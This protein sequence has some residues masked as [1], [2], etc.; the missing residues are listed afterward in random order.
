MGVI[1]YF[2]AK[3]TTI[4]ILKD[5]HDQRWKLDHAAERIAEINGRLYSTKSASSDT[6]PVQ[7]GANRTEDNLCA[8]IDKKEL[9]LHGLKKAEE[10]ERDLS[11]C[12]DRL[13]DDER[14]CLT[15]RFID[16][17][18]GGGIQRIMDRLCVERSEAYRRSDAALDRLSKLLFW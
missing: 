5:W 15:A 6:V 4:A 2:D 7:G 14:F 9:L 10:Y 16:H 3:R 12:W 11:A 18:E 17:E 13:T 1:D 8:G